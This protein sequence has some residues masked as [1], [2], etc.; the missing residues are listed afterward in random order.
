MDGSG[1]VFVADTL[2]S[3]VKEVPLGCTSAD[4]VTTVGGGFNQPYGV[5]VAGGTIYVAD[6]GTH[7]VYQMPYTCN[8]ASCATMMGGG[9][10]SPQGLAVDASGNVYVA[11]F[12]FTDTTVKEIRPD[13]PLP[14]ASRRW[15]AA[16]TSPTASRSTQAATST[17]QIPAMEW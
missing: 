16:S 13:A 10:H 17:S 14:V 11:D 9:L 5:A 3:A 12:N 2:N 8:S 7:A 1:N 6:Y 15:A 4:C